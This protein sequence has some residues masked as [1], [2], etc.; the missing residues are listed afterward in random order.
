MINYK[1]RPS[2]LILVRGK[3]HGVLYDMLL[4]WWPKEW[5]RPSPSTWRLWWKRRSS[6]SLDG[7]VYLPLSTSHIFLFTLLSLYHYLLGHLLYALPASNYYLI[8]C[9]TP[10][11]L[12]FNMLFYFPSIERQHSCQCKNDQNGFDP[13]VVC[14]FCCLFIWCMCIHACNRL[15]WFPYILQPKALPT[16]RIHVL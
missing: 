7:G 13:C 10:T 2:T 9:R 5:R 4:P 12:M 3:I 8:L 14:D 15:I 16:T 11:P 6:S 1:K